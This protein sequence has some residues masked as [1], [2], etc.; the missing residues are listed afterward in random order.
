LKNRKQCFIIY[1]FIQEKD[2]P[3]Q[4]YTMSRMKKRK[5]LPGYIHRQIG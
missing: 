3:P 1:S 5:V 4:R 2:L